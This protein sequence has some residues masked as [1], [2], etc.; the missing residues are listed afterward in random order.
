MVDCLVMV[1]DY[2]EKALALQKMGDHKSAEKAFKVMLEKAPNDPDALHLL[3]LSLHAQ[4]RLEEAAEKI[5]SAITLL[6]GQAMFHTHAGVVAVALGDL[7]SGTKHY[8]T[9]IECDPEYV[10]AYSNF[11]VLLDLS[12]QCEEALVVLN[13]GL[14]HDEQSVNILV[15]RG[16]VLVKLGCDE[17]AEASYRAAIGLNSGIAEAHNNLGNLLKR[18]KRYDEAA[19]AFKAALT[20][21][22]GFLDARYN[23]ALSLAGTGKVDE[24]DDI[25]ARLIGERPEPHFFIARAGLMQA[26]PSSLEDVGLWRQRFEEGFDLLHAKRLKYSGDPLSVPVMNF[27]LAYHGKNDRPLMEKLSEFWR[28]ACPAL[29]YISDPSTPASSRRRVGFFSRYLKSHAVGH[30][31]KGLLEG[32]VD[33]A[34]DEIEVVL[35]SLAGDEDKGWERLKLRVAD[36]LTLPHDLMSARKVI[37]ELSLSILIYADIGM[38]SFSYYLS[39]ARL[40]PIQC[41]LWGHPVTSGV[42]TVDYYISSDMAEPCKA[43]DHYTEKLI[44]LGGVQTCYQ[45]PKTTGNLTR[46]EANLPENGTLYMCPQSLFKIHPDMDRWLARLIKADTNGRLVIFEGDP[47]S[48][49]SRLISRWQPIFGNALD[50]VIVLQR[51]DWN[52][53]LN[54]LRLGDVILDT[55]PFGG[56]NTNYQ[57]FGF[58]LPVVTLPGEFIRGLGAKALYEHMGISDCIA[59]SPEDYV[60]IALNI[61]QKQELRSIISSK[62][63]ERSELIFN[64]T[65]VIEDLIKFLRSV[66]ISE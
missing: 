35:I 54:R 63:L 34:G 29:N 62:I 42:S 27:Y 56:G 3:G 58:G 15:N 19:T 18:Q 53:F 25:L 40:A 14:A 47:P 46:R 48:F 28:Q 26:I 17:E 16:K 11:G 21:R 12:G 31:L 57:A 23:W 41:V 7:A 61:G 22:P 36:S 55:W 13:Q 20:A 39:F 66:S 1:D 24:A 49:T 32:L 37:S 52:G 38:D 65:G 50:R 60:N 4:G 8:Q 51:T 45:R 30:T 64:D 6:P 5:A 43:Q 9:A 59:D 10:D 44:R 33:K 2:L